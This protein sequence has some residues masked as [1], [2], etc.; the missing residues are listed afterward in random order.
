M[1]DATAAAPRGAGKK[2]RSPFSLVAHEGLGEVEN[3]EPMSFGRCARFLLIKYAVP[4]EFIDIISCQRILH[5]F[6]CNSSE[7]LKEK[8]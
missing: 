4:G 7:N 1:T 8:Y 2:F 6:N 3:S 5:A